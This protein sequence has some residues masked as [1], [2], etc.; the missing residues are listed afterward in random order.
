MGRI[1]N[2][3]PRAHPIVAAAAAKYLSDGLSTAAAAAAAVVE[4]SGLSSYLQ[5]DAFLNEVHA[6]LN[7]WIVQIRKVTTLPYPAPELRARIASAVR[8][9]LVLSEVGA[10]G[11]A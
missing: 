7:H 6:T 11:V 3:V 5:D 8:G 9:K 2:V 4:S 1:P 10:F